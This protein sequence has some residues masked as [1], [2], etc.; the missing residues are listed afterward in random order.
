[1]FICVFVCV[2]VCVSTGTVADACLCVRALQLR[3]GYKDVMESLKDFAHV[4]K[5]ALVQFSH[6]TSEREKL[7]QV[8]HLC[9][10]V[11]FCTLW[12]VL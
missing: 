6:F 11:L 5:K 8:S 2:F 4:N 1:M 7:L 9:A 10:C 12:C 3:S